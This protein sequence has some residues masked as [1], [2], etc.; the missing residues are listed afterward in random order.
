[1]IAQ[2]LWAGGISDALVKHIFHSGIAAAHGVANDDQIGRRLQMYSI[3]AL[4][5]LYAGLFELCAHGWINI[6]VAAGNA[7][8]QCFSKLRE[9]AHEGAAHAENMNMHG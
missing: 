3:E 5:K 9:T 8:A 4:H 7:M 1:M 6:G 2:P